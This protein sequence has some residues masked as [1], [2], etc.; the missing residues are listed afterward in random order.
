MKKF[1]TL[2]FLALIST[3]LN[4]QTLKWEWQ[5]PKPH[6]NDVNDV[7]YLGKDTV[8]AVTNAGY[9]QKSI[10]GGNSWSVIKADTSSRDIL[11]VYFWDANK[12]ILCGNA[13][14]LMETKDAG[15]SWSYLNSGATDD[16]YN[17][18]FVDSD[19]GYVAAG[20]GTLLKTIDGGKTWSSSNLG[21]STNYKVFIV[22]AS[23][24]FLGTGTTGKKLV[25]S[26][27]YG[28][29]WT[30]VA[31]STMTNNVYSIAFTDSLTG[32]FGNSND[33]IYKSKDGGLTWTKKGGTASSININDIYFTDKANGYAVDAKGNFFFTSDSGETWTNKKVPYQ[34]F[35]A[36]DGDA[37]VLYAAGV[38]GTVL[39]S[40]DKGNSW[41]Q[42]YSSITQQY[43]RQVTFVD[44]KTGYTCGGST[45]AADSLGFIL[46]TTDGGA[47]WSV[48]SDQ[49]K[50]MIYA[51]A[52]PT[53]D[54][55]CAAGTGNSIFRSV[56]AGKT[57]T[58]IS[59]P[60]TGVATMVFYAI[61][62]ADKDTGYAV[63]NAG[64]VIKTTDGGQTW[65]NLTTG[66]ASSNAVWDLAVFNGKTVII[67]ASLGKALKT[68]DG[69]QTW[70]TLAP[71]IAGSLF[72]TKFKDASTGY[73]T[74]GSKTLTRTSDGGK[75]W[76]AMDLPASLSSSAAIWGAAFGKDADWI[77]SGNGD[78]CYSA[79]SGKT[80]QVAP[81]MTSSTLIDIASFGDNIWIVGNNGTILHGSPSDPSAVEDGK[82][83]VV[84]DF[85]LAQN[86]PNPFNPSTT[87]RY[88]VP[89]E[90][91]V[92]LKVYNLIGK[93]VAQLVNESQAAGTHSI[94]FDA[95]KLSS[96]I[97]FYEL[98]TGSNVAAKKMIL[99]K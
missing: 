3:L 54:I 39:Q 31:P 95:S 42:K 79:D 37:S 44:E 26:V 88:T 58:K 63:G 91:M 85:A 33:D 49:F 52:M 29:T 82:P 57:W 92:S 9:V 59:S 17:V 55:W 32:F 73:I 24:I 75:T 87:I 94:Q 50:Y 65:T 8:I 5:N 60:V 21:S 67:S 34:K 27:D 83:S 51:F 84:K 13:G 43:L 15:L 47:N 56:D 14:L 36:L 25:R 98:R 61:A 4:A 20:K 6:G 68:V 99:I 78:I 2:F 1:Y 23:D 10:D 7:K 28:K 90:G 72:S 86:Y 62:F 46:K 89:S 97:Y 77:I 96:G 93:E 41:D 22:N 81:A 18:K 53:A 48:L 64:K 76:T 12:G 69:G 11:S 40:K 30:N 38:A 71:N 45:V 80:W 35:N 74:G 16:L 70:E 66:L 19:T